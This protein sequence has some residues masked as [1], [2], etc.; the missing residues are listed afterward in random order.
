MKISNINIS[1]PKTNFT[2]KLDEIMFIDHKINV[3]IGEN[4]AGKS[5]LIKAILKKHGDCIL[6]MQSPYIFNKTVLNSMKFI[7]KLA[8]SPLDEIAILKA[9]N[10]HECLDVESLSLS[11]GQKQRLALAMALMANKSVIILDEPFN[12][13]DVASQKLIVELIKKTQDKTF[14]IVTH[15]LNH[16]KSYGEQFFY[17]KAG[18]LIWEGD[19]NKFFASEAVQEFISLE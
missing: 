11:G 3:I 7:K 5:V 19:R 15:K 12:G 18:K 6:M 1:Y 8:N 2:M 10:L 17:F 13:I 14:I 9:V 4:G 16:A